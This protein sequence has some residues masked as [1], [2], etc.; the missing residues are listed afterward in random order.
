MA[1][2]P[3]PHFKVSLDTNMRFDPGAGDSIS[4]QHP[5]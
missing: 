4:T 3:P 2:E 1:P 5:V